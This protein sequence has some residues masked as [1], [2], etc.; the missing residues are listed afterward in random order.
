MGEQTFEERKERRWEQHF[1]NSPY[2]G[3]E[4]WGS[5]AE[6]EHF[7]SGAL[8]RDLNRKLFEEEF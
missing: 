6:E 5:L 3:Q 2:G 8:Q 1:E 4:G 7:V